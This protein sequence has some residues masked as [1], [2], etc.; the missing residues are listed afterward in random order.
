LR[1][2]LN[3]FNHSQ[4][5]RLSLQDPS[6]IIVHQL[7]SLGH[8][9]DHSD[10]EFL[11]GKDGVNLIFEGFN[12]LSIAML[13]EARRLHDCRFIFVATEEPCEEPGFVGFNHAAD[14][15]MVL[16]QALFPEAAK[17]ADAVLALVPNTAHWYGQYAPTEQIELGYS[18]GMMRPQIR[19]PDHDFGFYGSVSNRRYKILRKLGRRGTVKLIS[20]H[21][22]TASAQ[23]TRDLEMQSARIIVQI[24]ILEK[25]GL[26]S[27]SRCASALSLGR[28]VIAEPHELAA[29]WN[30]IISFAD[31]LDGFYREA[32]SYKPFWKALYAKQFERFRDILTPAACIGNALDRL[33][34]VPMAKL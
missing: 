4:I 23:E 24:R 9:I 2:R 28:P 11:R 13:K 5:G 26:V 15:F 7:R 12:L 34:I 14:R 3:L 32:E 1:F 30:Q 21:N 27:S 33:G 31:S 10:D 20:L 6:Q 17:Y 22:P 18:P 29:P 8:Q 25:M 16:R 19:Q